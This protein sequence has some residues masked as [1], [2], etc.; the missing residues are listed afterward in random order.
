MRCLASFAATLGQRE[1]PAA[2]LDTTYFVGATVLVMSL[3]PPALRNPVTEVVSTTE[4][5]VIVP[6]GTHVYLAASIFEEVRTQDKT[7]NVLAKLDKDVVVNKGTDV[8][9]VA[10]VISVCRIVIVTA[11]KS[12]FKFVEV[13]FEPGSLDRSKFGPYR[14]DATYIIIV[15]RCFKTV[16]SSLV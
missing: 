15:Y 3:T 1:S 6:D 16:F 8:D 11:G 7:I 14:I 13:V 10:V 2:I 4:G 5:A 9:I 12:R